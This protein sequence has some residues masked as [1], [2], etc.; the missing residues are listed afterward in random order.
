M[1]EKKEAEYSPKLQERIRVF[2]LLASKKTT[3]KAASKILKLSERQIRRLTK[4]YQ[5]YGAS[6]LL[7]KKIGQRSNNK[8]PDNMRSFYLDI[9]RDKYS[10]FGPTFAHEK[11][12]E[13]HE[14]K[15]SVE[16]LRQ[17]MIAENIWA[18]H[19]TPKKRE[20]RLR[21]RRSCIG[22]LIQIDGSIHQW[23]EDRGDKCVLLL[24]IDDATS[25]ILSAKFVPVEI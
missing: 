12:T 9:V 17:W 1:S 22:E 4:R 3:Q 24:G 18:P 5:C 2:E 11:L 16:T 7:S 20:H 19:I 8:F 13:L 15:F 25:K 14:A 10:D 23:F 21:E 6:G